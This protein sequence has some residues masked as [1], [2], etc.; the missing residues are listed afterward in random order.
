M[1]LQRIH[2]VHILNIDMDDYNKFIKIQL[3]Y[4]TYNKFI[5]FKKQMLFICGTDIFYNTS[6]KTIVI[7]VQY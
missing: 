5:K 2:I 4:G 7:I 3:K 6:C 1:S